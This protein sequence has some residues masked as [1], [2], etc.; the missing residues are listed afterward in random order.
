MCSK[1]DYV[2]IAAVFAALKPQPGIPADAVWEE[3]LRG[4]ARHFAGDNSRFDAERF[5]AAAG[6][7]GEESS[8]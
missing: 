1:K 4:V 2:A 6:Y 8:Q 7:V 3:C 5:Y